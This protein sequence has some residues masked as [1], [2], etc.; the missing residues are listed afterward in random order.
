MFDGFPT[1]LYPIIA[2]AAIFGAFSRFG[3]FLDEGNKITPSY[4]QNVRD[5]LNRINHSS[6][7]GYF[8]TLHDIVFCPSPRRWPRISRSL[9]A[10][11]IAL[12]VVLVIWIVAQFSDLRSFIENK[13]ASTA[14]LILLTIS[15]AL[16]FN[17]LGDLFSDWETRVIIDRMVQTQSTK[18]RALLLLF[19]LG[20]SIGVFLV[21]LIFGTLFLMANARLLGWSASDA[22]YFDDVLQYIERIIL[23]GGWLFLDGIEFNVFGVFFVTT[24]LTSVWIWVFFIG[25]MLW[26]FLAFLTRFLNSEAY[27]IGAAMTIGGGFVGL[28]LTLVMYLCNW[29]GSQ[30]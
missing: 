29:G 16:P 6:W 27:P 7:P 14:A 13:I 18:K 2:G 19:D 15:Y 4:R 20:A 25:I 3:Y 26:P 23:N 17:L 10:S 30:N 5:L 11:T 1:W 24:L 21:G 22:S 9:I 28:L 12:F 8:L